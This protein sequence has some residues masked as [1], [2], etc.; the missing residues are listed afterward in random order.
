MTKRLTSVV[1]LFA[2]LSACVQNQPTSAPIQLNKPAPTPSLPTNW[3]TDAVFYEIFVRSFY[4]TDG[5]G[6]GDFNG[7][8]Q[9][10]DYL[11]DLGITAIWLMPI[12]PS[13]SYHGYDVTNYYNVN[14][15]YGSMD[16]FKNLLNETHKRDIHLIIDLVLNH[17]SD[18]HPWFKAAVTDRNSPYRD[19]YIWSD[20]K[21]NYAGPWGEMVWHSSPTGY[22]YGL[23]VDFM[24]DL[25]YSNPMVSDEAEKITA[26]WLND[27]GVDGFRLDAAKHLIEDGMVQENT[28]A[29]HEWFK[30]YRPFYK[31]L[32][33]DAMTIGEVAG[34]DQIVMAG[35]TQGDQLD[36]TFDFG[37]AAAILQAAKTGNALNITG[38]MKLTYKLVPNLQYAT[39]LTNHDQN[40]VMS[41]LDGNIDKAKIAASLLLTAPGVP[42][43][44]YGEEIGLEGQKPDEDIRRP[45]QWSADKFAGFSTS[46]PWR[47]PGNN[48]TVLNVSTEL[49]DPNSLLSH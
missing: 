24:P 16:D 14:P 20:T 22:Y 28:A 18:Q 6:T 26:F 10:L 44:Y 9:K 27:V 11:K 45:M 46:L 12:Q 41:E 8:T 23:F 33:P 31:G 37:Q 30:R 43:L 47:N 19:W 49:K 32:N 5:N 42:F 38:P 13:P 25:N 1:L 7:I 34:A 2:V 29:T 4:D 36:L 15:E 35:Y 48:Y 39:F 21:P 40:R 17:T 3:W